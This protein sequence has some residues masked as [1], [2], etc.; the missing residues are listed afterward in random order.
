MIKAIIASMRPFF[1]L[2]VFFLGFSALS[3]AARAQSC[4]EDL[5]AL[6]KSRNTEIEALN[7][8]SKAHGNKLDPIAACPH[9]RKM[10][11]IEAKMANYFAKNKDWCNIPDDFLANFK[12]NTERTAKIAEQACALA[13]KAKQMQESGGGAGLGNLPPPPK[14]PAGPL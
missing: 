9:L 13:A 7:A 14:L 8:I 11:E 12:Q 6:G 5:A 3:G 1:L 2:G 10:K 4:N